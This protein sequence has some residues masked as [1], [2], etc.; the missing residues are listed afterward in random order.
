MHARALRAPTRHGCYQRARRV[1]VEAAAP[2]ACVCSA[3]YQR[4]AAPGACTRSAPY[5]RSSHPIPLPNLA[6][7]TTKCASCCTAWTSRSLQSG[8][9]RWSSWS[10]QAGWAVAPA[11]LWPVLGPVRH[12]GGDAREPIRASWC[13][14]WRSCSPQRFTRFK[15]SIVYRGVY[16]PAGENTSLGKMGSHIYPN[17]HQL[18]GM[19]HECRP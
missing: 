8:A 5:Q 14:R 2:S 7:P 6:R 9:V 18:L 4:S 15:K 10:K 17:R 16:G 11:V 3:P 19:Q 13:L 12:S 1:W